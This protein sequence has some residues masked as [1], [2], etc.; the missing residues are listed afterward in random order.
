MVNPLADTGALWGQKNFQDAGFGNNNL[1]PVSIP[2][3]AANKI[4]INILDAF[5]ATVIKLQECLQRMR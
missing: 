3:R 2:I 1:L 4:A 5:R